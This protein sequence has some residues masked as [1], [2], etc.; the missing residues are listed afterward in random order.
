VEEYF[1]A[2]KEI[3]SGCIGRRP[4]MNAPDQLQI[5][6]SMTVIESSLPNGLDEEVF[7]EA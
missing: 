6:I 2:C 4:A 5:A 7:A 1:E 3:R